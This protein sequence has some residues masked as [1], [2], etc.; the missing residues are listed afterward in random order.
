M[1]F[2]PSNTIFFFFQISFSYSRPS[3]EDEDSDDNAMD[4]VVDLRGGLDSDEDPTRF[5]SL[6]CHLYPGSIKECGH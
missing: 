4:N 5:I 2:L 3:S 1:F 6:H